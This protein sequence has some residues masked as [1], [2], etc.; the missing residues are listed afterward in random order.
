MPRVSKRY[1]EI[2]KRTK[3][4]NY[5]SFLSTFR[6]IAEEEDTHEDILDLLF[7][8]D[9]EECKQTR[10][11]FRGT[12]QK[13]EWKFEQYFMD[14]ETLNDREFLHAFRLSRT[15]I[16]S[17]NNL[18]KKD[19]AFQSIPGKKTKLPS[20]YHL[21]VLLK[22]LRTPSAN[23]N[24]CSVFF[25]VSVGMIHNC[26]MR[27]VTVI[28][29]K[30]YVT[31]P[32]EEERKEISSIIQKTFGFPGCVGFVDGTLLPLACCPHSTVGEDYWCRK[33]FYAVNGLI[34]CDHLGRFRN[35]IVGW[36]GCVHDNRVFRNCNL[37]TKRDRY[38]GYAEY[39][40]GDSAFQ[41][42]NIM[43]PCFKKTS[44]SVLSVDKTNFNTMIARCQIKSEHSI[45][46]L[47]ARFPLF[48]C[49]RFNMG[50]RKQMKR[51]VDFFLVACSL[52]NLLIG[53]DIPP[54]WEAAIEEAVQLNIEMTEIYSSSL[55]STSQN[56]ESARRR[57]EIFDHMQQHFM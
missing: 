48:R 30:N 10:Y 29:K 25:N 42:S 40:I 4:V 27:T 7:R 33:G 31:W 24:D 3:Y 39:I 19:K 32:D 45:G 43:V 2:E 20:I 38:F 50:T 17:I 44:N 1:V 49:V 54:Q 46:L 55:R 13:R 37:N 23:Y 18:L 21:L 8:Q 35:C 16:I 41:P 28:L 47:K 26:L 6:S 22:F 5:R 56:D 12:Q 14:K 9:L 34:T 36:P 15:D 11:L 52:H 51:L 53:T 57:N